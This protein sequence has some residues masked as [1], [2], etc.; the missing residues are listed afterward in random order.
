MKHITIDYG[1]DLGTTN[2]AICRME[3]GEPVIIRSD[4]GM[5][6]MP[7]CVSFKK[8]GTI[9]IGQSAY[10]DLG[11]DKLRAL[12]KKSAMASNSCIEFK[13][14]M[15][16]DKR[17]SN[18]NAEHPWSPEELSAQIVKTLCSFV[19]D[20]KVKAA[21]ITVPAKFTVNQKDATLEAA[22][23]AGIGQVELLQEP[24]AASIA[25]GLK[26]DDKNGIWMVFDFGGGTLD[27]ALVHVSDGIMQVFDTEGDNYLGGKNVD[28][29]I[30]SK[31]ILPQITRKY[32]LDLSD[33]EQYKLLTEALKVEAE[34]A[35][36]KLSYSDSDTIYLEAGDWGEDE[37]GEEIELEITISR[38]ELEDAIKPIL[39]KAVDICKT[40]M[41]R[42][43]IPYG[44]LSHLILIGGPTFMPLLRKMLREQVTENVGTGINPMTAVA[45]G[46]AIYASTIPM[47]ID[48]NDIEDDVLQLSVDFESTTVDTQV[49]I[50]VKPKKFTQNLKV[51]MI[52]RADGMES[53]LV[54][55]IE[56]GGLIELDLIPKQPNTFRIVAYVNDVEVKCFPSELTIVQGTKAGTAI[57][58]Y[59]IGIEVYNPKKN[60]CIFT[61]FTGLE[62]NRPLPAVGTVYGLKTLSD[63]HPGKE[64]DIVRIAVY[65]GDDSAE[66][67][68][69]A[70]F[71]YVSDV[72]V[73]GEDI[74]SFI[75]QGSLVNI[76]I[77]VNRSEM[78]TIVADFP[79]SGQK[80]EKHLDTSRR[81]EIKDFDYLKTQIMRATSQLNFLK[82]T[83]DDT[84]EIIRINNQIQ[85]IDDALNS[86]AQHKQIEQHL[87][88][89]LR[90]I[91]DYEMATEWDRERVKLQRAL[92]S[93]QISVASRKDS[94]ANRMV[95]SFIAQVDR[96][97]ALKDILRARTLH[98]QIENYEYSLRQDEI[99]RNFIRW[100]DCDFCS[101][102]WVNP[103]TA[104]ELIRNAKDILKDDPEAPLSKTKDIAERIAGLLIRE[105]IYP[106]NETSTHFKKY[107]IDLPS[108]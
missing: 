92:M 71:E 103:K 62:K 95:E 83:I 74:I 56:Q 49:F 13:R 57:L 73:S 7:S 40:L 80:V 59:N 102:K 9:R 67:K 24:I 17:F 1:I 69:A 46:A 78:M 91:E 108:M 35:K 6:T 54:P 90:S 32:A 5:E 52:R 107:R 79:E 39:Q 81:Q 42:N 104:Q 31:I 18:A 63:L 3:H 28:E 16:S 93:L 38:Q 72:I 11:N 10:A 89:V 34:K 48:E 26:A 25:Y 41:L 97:I 87:K 82:E 61:A 84:E 94:S 47:K 53:I 20:D 27:V 30:V 60:R 36:H 8:G 19:S 15:G 106:D 77:D 105:D 96:T 70:L 50:P 86:G 51:K 43:N 45:T 33:N 12:K 100:V 14:Y 55:I 99:Y 76:K 85:Q 4:S 65:Q 88:E 23:L 68:T 44:K 75:P 101:L 66:G 37:D 64:D 29:A 22:R 98:V 2:S 21:V 58:P